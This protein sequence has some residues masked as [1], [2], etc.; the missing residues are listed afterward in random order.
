MFLLKNF[1][2][3]VANKVYVAKLIDQPLRNKF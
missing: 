1:A 3:H 2:K